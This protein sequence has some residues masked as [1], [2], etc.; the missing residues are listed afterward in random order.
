MG[1]RPK[2]S[3]GQ[4]FLQDENILRK[5][6]LCTQAKPSDRIIEIGPGE[7]ALTQ[8]LLQLS[9][10]VLAVEVD[11]RAAEWLR[12]R[13]PALNLREEDFMK[14]PLS[15]LL[16]PGPDN[17]V[18]G[19]IP[20]NITSPILF[21]LLDAGPVYRRAVLLMQKEVAE[22]LVAGPGSKQYGIL[23]VQTQLLASVKY[24]FSVSRH[25][26]FPKPKVESAVISLEPLAG[27]LEVP[28]SQ[29]KQVVR[30]SFN[31]RR[32]KLSNSLKPLFSELDIT[33]VDFNLDLRPDQLQPSQ[34]VELTQKVFAT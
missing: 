23:S 14:V 15:D 2:K 12:D 8:L 33:D 9:E 6:A 24:E 27:P 13:F 28:L 19:N 18:A 10:D 25:V 26:F 4:H 32:K 11:G 1:I 7:G 5:I 31:Q 22:R 29:L 21:K 17:V 3:L 20:Y 16:K 34:F 30:T